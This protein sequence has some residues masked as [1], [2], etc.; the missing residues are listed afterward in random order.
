MHLDPTFRSKLTYSHRELHQDQ[1]RTK[2]SIEPRD[3]AFEHS[4]W[5]ANSNVLQRAD[6]FKLR[7][8]FVE[9]SQIVQ[10]VDEEY[11][12]ISDNM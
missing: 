11:N 12:T 10:A 9:H 6:I 2:P 5:I 4:S 1:A 8:T 7:R 3:V